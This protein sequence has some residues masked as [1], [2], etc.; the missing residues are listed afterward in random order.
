MGS[1]CIS[2]DPATRIPTTK[3]A[4]SST[5]RMQDAQEQVSEE[6]IIGMLREHDGVATADL[7]RRC[8]LSSATF[9]QEQGEVRRHDRLGRSAAVD[10]A[11]EEREAGEAPGRGDVGQRRAERPRVKKTSDARPQAW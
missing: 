8:A 3:I 9:L 7:C 10:V 6:Q 2:A 11:Q 1:T 5:E 4:E